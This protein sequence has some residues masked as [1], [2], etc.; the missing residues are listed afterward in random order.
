MSP[1]HSQLENM[2][3]VH[4]ARLHKKTNMDKLDVRQNEAARIITGCCKDTEIR[5]FALR[6]WPDAN[7]FSR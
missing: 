5:T 4:G 3:L 2:S 7:N 6:S 1:T